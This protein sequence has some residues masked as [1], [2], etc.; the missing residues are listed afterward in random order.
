MTSTNA[1]LNTYTFQ[2][3]VENNTILR[4]MLRIVRSQH[5]EAR[6]PLYKDKTSGDTV[7]ASEFAHQYITYTVLHPAKR[8]PRKRPAEEK[9]SEGNHK[10]LKTNA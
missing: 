8:A 1:K 2:E 6:T 3:L 4:N 10:K 5:T 7:T 9:Q